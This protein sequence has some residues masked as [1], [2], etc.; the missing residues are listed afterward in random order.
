MSPTARN[1]AVL[2]KGLGQVNVAADLA[3]V[4]GVL[5]HHRLVLAGVHVFDREQV[6]IHVHLRRGFFDSPHLDIAERRQGEGKL[7]AATGRCRPS[8][9]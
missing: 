9:R 5:D 3:T 1:G 8:D 7:R 2:R 6:E 4:V